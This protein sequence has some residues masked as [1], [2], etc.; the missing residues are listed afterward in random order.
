MKKPYPLW[1]TNTTLAT[2]GNIVYG[3]SP[4]CVYHVLGQDL[5]INEPWC[6]ATAA[7]IASLNILGKK[8]L[9]ELHKNGVFF[10]DQI[11]EDI[12]KKFIILERDIKINSVVKSTSTP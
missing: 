7:N 8:F 5:E 10:P 9:E 1:T 3:S 11:E 2:G 12:K 4:F 6:P